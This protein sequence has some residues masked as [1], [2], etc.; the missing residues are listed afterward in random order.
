M[1]IGAVEKN[2]LLILDIIAQYRTG[3]KWGS[4]FDVAVSKRRV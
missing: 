2:M 4:Y 3:H 1:G